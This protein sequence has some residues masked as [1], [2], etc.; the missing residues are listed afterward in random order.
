MVYTSEHPIFYVTTDIVVLTLMDGVLSAL[1][2][3]RDEEPH[4]GE[5]ALPGG[6]VRPEE[7]L[8]AAARRRLADE[9]GVDVNALVLEQLRTYGAPDRDWTRGRVVSV[10]HLSVIP[11]PLAASPGA[12]TREALWLPVADLAGTL[13]FDHNQILDDAIER[14][15]AKLEYTALATS[16]LDAEFTLA[17]LRSVYESI[18]GTDLDPGNFQR[19]IRNSEDFVEPTGQ[20]RRSSSGRGRPAELFRARKRRTEQLASPLTRVAL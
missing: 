13:A 20:T 5:L 19:K 9:T 2:V 17:E 14:T 12:R 18:W 3:R 6:F 1:A 7:D 16:F 8:A 10:A 15:K 4:A 11:A